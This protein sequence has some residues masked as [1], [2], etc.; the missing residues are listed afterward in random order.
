MTAIKSLENGVQVTTSNT[1][2]AKEETATYPQVLCT[3]PFPVMR[4]M[5]LDGLSSE[6]MRAI[7]N[8]QYGSAVKVLLLS[9]TR[10]WEKQG[11]CGGRS[12]TDRLSREIYYPSDFEQ[13]LDPYQQLNYSVPAQSSG[14]YWNVQT[15]CNE[16]PCSSSMNSD[17]PG[18]LLG[19]YSFNYNARQ[20]GRLAGEKCVEKD[21]TEREKD[22][23]SN[24]VG[25]PSSRKELV[26]RDMTHIHEELRENVTDCVTMDWDE[27][28]WTKGAVGVNPTGDLTKYYQD[29]RKPEKRLFFAGEHI[30]IAP[31]WI[32]GALES[33]LSATLEMLKQDI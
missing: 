1:E 24:Q 13:Q 21:P 8:M 6:K 16:D 18:V 3:L 19:S 9:K 5:D 20:L 7:R 23:Y 12:V 22:K 11:I 31:A 15:Q 30:S 25:L 14:E 10:F 29:G 17:R 4:L 2:T 33:S 28:P 27:F 32:Q 26:L